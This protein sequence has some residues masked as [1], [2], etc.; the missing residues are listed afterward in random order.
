MNQQKRKILVK[1]AITI[2]TLVLCYVLVFVVMRRKVSDS[3]VYSM[4]SIN[5]AMEMRKG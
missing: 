2:L 3:A 1:I 5:G 4:Y